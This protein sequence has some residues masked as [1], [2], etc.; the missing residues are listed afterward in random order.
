MDFAR[1]WLPYLYLYGVGGLFFSVTLA[2]VL[3]SG[4]C[5]PARAVD[6]RWRRYLVLGLLWT[7]G[8][9]GAVTLAA[10]CL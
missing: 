6:R 3:R 5:R 9:H 8:L 2:L 1:V 4:A 10:L 7:A